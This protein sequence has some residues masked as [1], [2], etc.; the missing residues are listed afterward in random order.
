MQVIESF[1]NLFAKSRSFCLTQFTILANVI[2]E[3]AVLDELKYDLNCLVVGAYIKTVVLDNV[4][5][6]EFF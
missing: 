1:E 2:L 5:M 3:T 6:I 4:G